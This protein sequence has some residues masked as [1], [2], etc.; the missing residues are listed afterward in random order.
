MHALIAAALDRSRTTILVLLF[1]LC[2][3]L[4]AYIAMPK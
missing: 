2:G 3:G 4:V 1:L